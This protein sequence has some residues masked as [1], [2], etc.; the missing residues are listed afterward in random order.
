MVNTDNL[1]QKE[2]QSI[3]LELYKSIQPL[4]YTRI[5][6][7]IDENSEKPYFIEF[8]VCCNLGKHAAINISANS[9]GISHNQLIEN[10]TLSSM[11]R[12]H[13]IEIPINKL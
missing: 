8:N 13:L 7:I 6:F 11:Y 3:A 12:Q 4:D 1:L 2:I 9:V 5:D 10:I